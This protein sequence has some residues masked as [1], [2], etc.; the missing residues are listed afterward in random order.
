MKRPAAKAGSAPRHVAARVTQSQTAA[1]SSTG[2]GSAADFRL[3]V[4]LPRADSR[5]VLSDT[6]NVSGDPGIP[7]PVF[8]SEDEDLPPLPFLMC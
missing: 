7:V 5:A 3:Q 1:E 4:F 8:D 2:A 6:M